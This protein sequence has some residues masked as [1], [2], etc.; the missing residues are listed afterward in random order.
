MLRSCKGDGG[1]SS[2]IGLQEQV[3]NPHELLGSRALVVSVM[4]KAL[5]NMSGMSQK[6]EHP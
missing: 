4:E 2:G 5:Q 6:D 3:P 1:R